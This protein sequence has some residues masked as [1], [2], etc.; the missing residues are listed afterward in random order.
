M[1]S[2][3]SSNSQIPFGTLAR[4]SF[5][6]ILL[7]IRL[8]RKQHLVFGVMAA[9]IA[10]TVGTYRPGSTSMKTGLRPNCSMG[11]IDVENVQA[12][13]TISS[14]FCR[15]SAQS[16]NKLAELPEFT[17]RPHFLPNNAATFSSNS[18]VRGPGASQPSRRQSTTACISSSPYASNLFGA[19]HTF[20]GGVPAQDALA[21]WA[22]S[23]SEVGVLTWRAI[24]STRRD[25][26]ISLYH[27]L[28]NNNGSA[29]LES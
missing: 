8:G 6:S 10:S 24:V 9:K 7:P 5:Q 16:P 25:A 20:F 2:A 21:I 17:M 23:R 3:E 27:T 29:D 26:A 11:A 19:Y 14:P 28:C 1:V 12:G 4:R 15:P 22:L 18:S 13:V